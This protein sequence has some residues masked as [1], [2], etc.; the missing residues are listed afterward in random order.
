MYLF[1]NLAGE[2]RVMEAYIIQRIQ[3]SPFLHGSQGHLVSF[4]HLNI[5]Q[6][7]V[8]SNANR[9]ETVAQGSFHRDCYVR[10]EIC[11]ENS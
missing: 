6:Y 9:T 2:G 10:H 5:D 11:L 4:E 8:S 3:T 7:K 1:S